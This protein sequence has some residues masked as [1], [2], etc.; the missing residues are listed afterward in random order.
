MMCH[1]QYGYFDVYVNS[2]FWND[3]LMEIFIEN[4]W[5]SYFFLLLFSGFFSFYVV[6]VFSNQ[7]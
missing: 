3:L 5:L 4:L 1:L 6:V 7:F 2:H